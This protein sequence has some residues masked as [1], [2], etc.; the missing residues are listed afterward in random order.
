MST[1]IAEPGET[2][3]AGDTA[4]ARTLETLAFEPIQSSLPAPF[5]TRLAVTPLVGAH[6][7]SFDADAAR[8][9]DLDPAQ[10]QRPEFVAYLN[11]ERPWPGAEPS[12]MVYA[13]H[14]F[15]V[16]VPQ[17]GDGRAISFG[18]VRNARGELWDLQSKGAGPT[19]YSR[20][21]DG[22]AVLRSTIREYLCSAAMHALGG[23]TT[24]ALAIVASS[25]PVVRESVETGALVLRMAPSHI[26]FG[27][28]EFFFHR[29]QHE[30]VRTLA[31]HVIA[32]HCPAFARRGGEGGQPDYAEWFGDI[33]ERTARMI[34]HWQAVGFAHGVM[35]TDNMSI[36]GITL[37]Y[38]PFGFLEAFDAGLIC[39]HS[40]EG[41]RYAFDNQP[42]IG[43]WN[44]ACLAQALTPLLEVDTL[45]AM[46]ARYEPAYSGRFL[47][48]M[49]AKLG[50]TAARDDDLDLVRELFAQMQ[51][52][53]A[54]YTIVFRRLCDL[55]ASGGPRASAQVRDLFLDRERFERWGARYRARVLEDSGSETFDDPARA[56]R[57]R[58]V[59]PKFILRNYLAQTAIEAAQRGDY[60]EIGRLLH[61]LQH[62]FDEHPAHESY[63]A[64]P[65]D[66]AT[67]I[68]VSCSS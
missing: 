14:Q 18:Q 66:W 32:H 26:R 63:A 50:L 48:L 62:P 37:D 67:G 47:A 61:L 68:A 9:I 10:V 19:P 2:T 52:S 20:F 60:A 22:R 51:H 30:L 8:L 41:G 23:P 3:F 16:Y 54:D 15:G 17:L 13:G 45:K 33:V 56:A 65:P 59:N 46:L 38:G 43:Y 28:F 4:A 36:H 21:A 35:N 40:D 53:R 31:D 11:G 5:Q 12:A 64:L 57:M 29:G 27:S 44:L 58:G 42:G 49:R 39:N 25:E 24:R 1:I 34:A 55:G 7:A 6:L